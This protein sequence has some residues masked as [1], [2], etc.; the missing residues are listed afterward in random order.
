VDARVHNLCEV[1]GQLGSACP[2]F[3]A[4][5][6]ACGRGRHSGRDRPCLLQSE[7]AEPVGG[8][9]SAVHE[10]VAARDDPALGSH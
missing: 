1:L 8:G 10:E 3:A 4:C 9:D 5:R 7:V 2:R 6:S